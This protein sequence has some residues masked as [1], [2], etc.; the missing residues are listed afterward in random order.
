MNWGRQGR[1]GTNRAPGRGP[2]ARRPITAAIHLDPDAAHVA[3]RPSPNVVKPALDA[4]LAFGPS[5]RPEIVP[6]VTGTRLDYVATETLLADRIVTF[7]SDPVPM[8]TQDDPANVTAASLA[9]NLPEADAAV[10][11]P[12]IL[13]FDDSVWHIPPDNLWPLLGVDPATSNLSVDR[14]PAHPRRGARKRDR[15]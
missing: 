10:D 15:P 11:A 12:L 3:S 7:A 5:G 14:R 4:R 6:D 9:P 1:S 2:G 8:V 13:S